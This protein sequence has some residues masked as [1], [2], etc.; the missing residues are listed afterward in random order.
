MRFSL[1]V[2]LTC[3]CLMLSMMAHAD[4]DADKKKEEK[5]AEREEKLSE[6]RL[7]LMRSR[8]A[9]VEVTSDEA[10]FPTKFA[11]KPVFRYTDPTLG[12]VA[13]AIWKLG[14][15]GRPRALMSTELYRLF[16]GSPRIVY[17]HLSL[18]P[19][20]FAISGGDTRW[21]PQGTALDFK[22]IPDAPA[23]DETAPRRLLQMRTI[24]KRFG[25]TQNA[26]KNKAELRLLPQPV[27]RYTPSS[28]DRADGGIFLFTLGGTNP[29]V[30][31]LLES[32]G[33]EWKFGVGR[34]T[35]GHP[36]VINIDGEPAW[37]I[38]L[39]KYG[40]HEPYTASNAPADIPGIARDGTEI[41][42]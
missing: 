17:E 23:P 9:R 10:G 35:A 30:A 7:E 31:M 8:M 22:S 15:E 36:V 4:D 42:E 38:P 39:H 33:K 20:H 19:T 2:G 26:G 21:A 40:Y 1:A 5:L 41:R 13:A 18:T 14:D 11:A 34:L 3:L 32:D 16:Y 29:E 37:E 12:Y 25:A 27:D 24:A 6:Q 28:A